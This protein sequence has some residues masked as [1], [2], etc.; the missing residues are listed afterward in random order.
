MRRLALVS[1]IFLL[2]GCGGGAGPQQPQQPTQPPTITSVTAACVPS[3]VEVNRTSQCTAQ[4][5]GTGDFSRAVTWSVQGGGTI[6][7]AGLYTA[8]PAVPNPPTVT[9]TATSVADPTKSGTARI[10]ILAPPP[11]I[12]VTVSPATADVQ[13]GQT[14]QFTATVTG[15]PDTRVRWLVNDVEGG[16]PTIGTITPSGLYTAPQSVPVPPT[17]TVKAVSVADPTRFGTATVTI[18]DCFDWTRY[19]APPGETDSATAVLVSQNRIVVADAPSIPGRQTERTAGILIYDGTDGVLKDVWSHSPV[20]S[21]I[22]SVVSHPSEDSFFAVGYTGGDSEHPEL[23]SAWFLKFSRT[24]PIRVLTERIFQLGGRRTEARAIAVQG[25][26]L[27]LGVRTADRVCYRHGVCTG[28]RVVV[29]DFQ[30]NIVRTFPVGNTEQVIVGDDTSISGISLT[31]TGVW[32]TGDI[33]REGV[34]QPFAY[35]LGRWSLTGQV[36]VHPSITSNST[37]MKVI[38]DGRNNIIFTVGTLQMDYGDPNRKNFLVD[39]NS[40]DGGLLR[41]RA[42][43]GDN[44]GPVSVNLGKGTFLSSAGIVVVGSLSQIG[45]PDPNQTDGGAVSWDADGNLLWK[46]RFTSVSGGTVFS[47]SAGAVDS[48][49]KVILV[50]AG[51]DGRTGCGLSLCPAVVVIKFRPVS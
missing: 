41:F 29:L 49:G 47:W 4:V 34:G 15:T 43:H 2:V 36:L 48:Q 13:V 31:P 5:A 45:N 51:S 37:Q 19:Y 10:T 30:G 27:Y 16:S 12:T 33:F 35:Y 17:V 24:E 50:G 6:T 42:W 3:Q 9:V 1:L 22:T 32:A 25:S 40:Q 18:V 26:N 44:S 46:R 11:P 21:R 7:A 38:E 39:Y 20:P 23:R 8:P 28:D 14:Q